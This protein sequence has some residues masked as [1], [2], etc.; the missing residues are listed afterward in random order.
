MMT[1]DDGWD[2]QRGRREFEALW[3]ERFPAGST[4]SGCRDAE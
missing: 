1:R 2:Y 3:R 4:A